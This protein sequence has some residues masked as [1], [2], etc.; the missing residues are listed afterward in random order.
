MPEKIAWSWVEKQVNRI[1]ISH[2]ALSLMVGLFV[3]VIYL[4]SIFGTGDE[5]LTGDIYLL[6]RILL[7]S[8]L[9]SYLLIGNR[10]MLKRTREIFQR[11]EFVAGKEDCA[12]K[13]YSK[14]ELNFKSPRR[15]IL[16]LALF[17]PPIIID[18]SDIRDLI[19]DIKSIRMYSGI[20]YFLIIDIFEYILFFLF[21]YYLM[22]I[23]WIIYNIS[24]IVNMIASI[25]VSELIKIDLFNEDKIGGLGWIRDFIKQIIAYYS[26]GITIA[27]LCYIDPALKYNIIFLLT[28]LFGGVIALVFVLESL[29]KIFRRRMKKELD[30]INKKYRCQYEV[31]N[32]NLSKANPAEEKEMQSA[33]KF[34]D[35][36]HKEREERERILEENKNSY[37][38]TALFIAFTSIIFPLIALFEKL[39]NGEIMN[40]ILY[41]FNMTNK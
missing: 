35:V 22:D 13:I 7:A 17:V 27:L 32:R 2:T 31:L 14:L 41:V 29:Q 19:Y 15:F 40:G 6:L 39:N 8:I 21:I 3:F 23:L 18:Y 20:D 10:F 28:L 37:S 4:I 30:D 12:E 33:M 24:R 36:L 38:F 34:I 26:A 11:L 9:L 25:Q 5:A 16:A 1:P